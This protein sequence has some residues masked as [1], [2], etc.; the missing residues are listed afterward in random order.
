MPSTKLKV[1][2][3]NCQGLRDLKKR[4][5]VL[6]YIADLKPDILCLQDTHWVK[7]DIKSIKNIWS[8]DSYINGCK[9][10]SRGVAILLSKS[11]D[12]NVC[13]VDRDEEGNFISLQLS[14]NDSTLYV[15]NI[16][17][18]NNDSPHFFQHL[19]NKLETTLFDYCIICGDFN[20]VLDP[21]MDT[22][23]YKHV[24]NPQARNCVL[25][26]LNTL[27]IKD[28]F[29]HFNRN[30]K[31]YTWHRKNPKQLARLDYFL[32]SDSL[33]DYTEK[34]NIIPGYRSDHSIVELILCF[35][36]FERGRGLWK[37]NCSLLKDKDYLIAINSIID[38]E[39]MNYALP[40]YHPHFLNNINDSIINFTI[41]DSDF[42]EILLLQIRGET[43]RYSSVSKKNM[44]IR[45]K[46][47]RKEIENLENSNSDDSIEL[48][49]KKKELETI[50]NKKLSG[51]LVRARAQWLAEGEKPSKYFCSLEKFFY[52]EK[53]IKKIVN[54][55]GI[56][57]TDQK[58]ILAEVKDFY[59]KLFK[60]NDSE[61]CDQKLQNIPQLDGANCLSEN[62]ALSL[63]DPLK[64]EEISTA[65]KSMKNQK[66]P[67]IDGFP[68][69]FFK[70]FWGK[71]KYFILRA[72]NCWF[73]HGEMSVSMRQ[74]VISCL[75]KGDKPRQFLKNWRPISL[76]SV[77]Y[78]IISSALSLRMRSVLN[79]LVSTC[80]SGFISGRFIG[81]NTRLIYDLI[82]YTKTNDIPGLLMLIDFQ[83]AFDC[84]SWT[85]LDSTLKFF[86]FGKNFCRWIKV[87]NSNVKAAI[88]Q[89]GTLSEFFNI[90]RGCRQG[91]P[92]SPYLFILCAQIMYLLVSKTKSIKG[93]TL[94]H[95]EYKISQF[96]DDTTLIM[97]GTKESLSAAL[98]VLK[99]FGS[100]SGLQIN[101]EKTK[102]VWIGKN[103]N[104]KIQFNV[105]KSLV[106]GVTT[107]NLL[108]IIFSTKLDDMI[109]LNYKPAMQ[110]LQKL[111]KSWN[112]RH[113]TPIGKITVIKTLALSKLN[114]LFLSLPSPGKSVLKTIE[115][116]FFKFIWSGKPDKIKRTTL[117]SNF[118]DG[119]LKMTNI[120]N[121]VAALKIS[122][123]RR[124]YNV[125][126]NG[127][128]WATLA[129]LI[130]GPSEKLLTLG[131]NYSAKIARETK[132]KFWCETLNS[133]SN[134]LVKLTLSKS[135]PE[136]LSLPIWYNNLISKA[137][138]FY[139]KWYAKG[140]TSVGDL[141]SSDGEILREIEIK[142]F[143]GI[144]TNFLE[145]HRVVKCVQVYFNT[146]NGVEKNHSKPI[147]PLYIQILLRSKKGCRDF[148]KILN[149]SESQTPSYSSWEQKLQQKISITTWKTIFRNCFKTIADNELIWFQYRLINRILGTNEYLTKISVKNNANCLLC[150]RASE[151]IKHLFIE[152]DTVKEFWSQLNRNI[153]YNMGI[154]CTITPFE[155]LFGIEPKNSHTYI[156]NVVYLV[157][158]VF[159][160]Q[161]AR[162]NGSISYKCFCEFLKK[163]YIEQEY[164]SKLKFM[165]TNFMRKWGSISYLFM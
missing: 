99:V 141:F 24:N 130:I 147:F 35:C 119:G 132:N 100:L 22:Y 90:E 40:V 52:T 47:L 74:C 87:L 108:G 38:K 29:R 135:L 23:N 89:C 115:D 21:S 151:T 43:I 101:V 60:A 154:D 53:T 63:E 54:D 162:S 91:D 27:S 36:K 18:P 164:T 80:Q 50:R 33:I 158:K 86:G 102:L 97:D 68:S 122:W 127:T 55:R 133:W 144:T 41:S 51:T 34:C 88:L 110:H 138:L 92:I 11:F 2:S 137:T 95:I 159:I 67:G 83:K 153:E 85:F 75:P 111:L 139:P 49:T 79:K 128:S 160:F 146:L 10:N 103:E 82:H 96:A 120:Y 64:L 125:H 106:W 126:S 30:L 129:R 72:A 143:Y 123:I 150:D 1:L 59:A 157:A 66:S 94:N 28:A 98:N 61:F 142:S 134:F 12:Y 39:K 107:F 93:I 7:D 165:H 57:L 5:D 4:T 62:E 117:T 37:F 14:I 163:I 113:M 26:L 70:V 105:G 42:L 136:A 121:F 3:A 156:I 15:S 9:T 73:E 48:E 155:I 20:L 104:S 6:N 76:L 109:E 152:C 116:M 149:R 145:Y 8:G 71:L 118:L 16:Y 112:H 13:T 25:E 131:S 140:I 31:K 58:K 56:V 65:L 44:C 45:E 77:I 81:E 32:I 46:N 148:Y 114:H 19:K 161:I 124:F 84:V 78:K 69:E 17:A